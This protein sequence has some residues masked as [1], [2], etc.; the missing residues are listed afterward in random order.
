MAK[1]KLQQAIADVFQRVFRK[2]PLTQRFED[3]DRQASRLVMLSDDLEKLKV[4]TGNTLASL[5][6]L[7]NEAGWDHQELV[8][9]SLA[10]IERRSPQ[11]QTLGRKT[12][13]A[14]LGGAF[15]PITQGH[16][17]TGQYVLDVSQYF[18]EIWYMPCYEHMYGK[19]L[20][21]VEHRLAMC[22]LA[23]MNH[24]RLKVFD[25]EITHK[26]K[27]E[28]FQT[29]KMLL[30]EEFIQDQY[31]LAW[32][33][34]QDNAN[35]FDQWVNHEYLQRMIPFVVV[36]RQG[37][38]MDP[39]VNWYLKRPHIFLGN[40]ERTIM[41]VSSTL[42]RTALDSYWKAPHNQEPTVSESLTRWL[43]TAVLG[44]VLDRRLYLPQE[45]SG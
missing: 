20:E 19:K 4:A 8:K 15:N 22:R 38:P 29:V 36:P 7:C 43:G 40:S 5:I 45:L 27:G 39:K 30:D 34:G 10:L 21:S 2:T 16:I 11:Y 1:S 14:I 13:V 33:I 25:Y 37:V 6:Q 23:T 42:V 17:Q 26:L 41:D 3:I 44:Y 31:E 32:I 18:D 9:D 24:G 35:T 12:R 28:T